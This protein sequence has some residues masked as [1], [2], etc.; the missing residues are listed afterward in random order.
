[1]VVAVATGGLP[2][3]LADGIGNG[4]GAPDLVGACLPLW[5]NCQR[6]GGGGSR[7]SVGGGAGAA[8]AASNRDGCLTSSPSFAIRLVLQ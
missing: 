1:M 6:D 7:P 8:M 5:F 4:E 2:A 3:C